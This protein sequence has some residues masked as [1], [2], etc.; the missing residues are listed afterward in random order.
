VK[1]SLEFK[2]TNPLALE[3]KLQELE[4]ALRQIRREMQKIVDS[5]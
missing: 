2:P 3:K 5:L 1:P 4:K